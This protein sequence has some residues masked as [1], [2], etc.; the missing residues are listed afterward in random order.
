MFM[1]N[2]K[3]SLVI[4]LLAWALLVFTSVVGL[5]Y[6]F[7]QARENELTKAVVALMVEA[8]ICGV[9]AILSNKVW[10]STEKAREEKELGA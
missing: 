10:K 2:D 5:F 1:N 3:A 9:F 8:L 4:G 6:A 7:Y